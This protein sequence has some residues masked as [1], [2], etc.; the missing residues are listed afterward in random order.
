MGGTALE[1]QDNAKLDSTSLAELLQCV[2][3]DSSVTNLSLRRSGVTPSLAVQLADFLETNSTLTHVDLSGNR[4]GEHGAACLATSL[5]KNRAV[6]SLVLADCGLT[7]EALTEWVA[8]FQAGTNTTLRYLNLADNQIDD[9]GAEALGAML[10]TAKTRDMNFDL[11]GNEL[12]TKG[13]QVLADAMKDSCP[14]A[15]TAIQVANNQDDDEPEA[16]LYRSRMEFYL[17]RNKA[18]IEREMLRETIMQ[19][20]MSSLEVEVCHLKHIVLTIAEADSLGVA[21]RSNHSITD[22]RLEDNALPEEGT[23]RILR[24]LCTNRSVRTLSIMDNNIGDGGFRALSD[25]L[26]MPT[27][28]IRTVIVGNPTQLTPENGLEAIASRTGSALHYTLANYALVTSLSLAN[29][30]L[31][32]LMVSVLVS[33]IAWSGRVEALDL[34]RNSFGNRS[35]H[36]LVRMMQRCLRLY[37]LDLSGNNFTLDGL[38]PLLPTV[39]SHSQLRVLLFGR[40]KGCEQRTM[41]EIVKAAEQSR[42]LVQL[43]LVTTNRRTS[44]R[45]RISSLNS[46]LRAAHGD[47]FEQERQSRKHELELHALGCRRRALVHQ[48][49]REV[50][51]QAISTNKHDVL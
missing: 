30:G 11:R 41:N 26:R 2:K 14:T 47:D 36:V 1:V 13:L 25:L 33:G 51:T 35:V 50:T 27:T 44:M 32:D 46:R 3:E 37:R 21:L 28:A 31:D 24:A 40:F 29:C 15:V 49:A 42:T 22:L 4:L 20:E 48:K 10:Q 16:L 39:S 17:R 23:R 12:S 43:E 34:Q 8:F 5:M 6:T 7:S 45:E 38:L 19:V 18:A 9:D